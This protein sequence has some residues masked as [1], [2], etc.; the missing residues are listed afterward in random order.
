MTTRREFLTTAAATTAV[1]ASPQLLPAADAPVRFGFSIAKTGRFASAATSQIA[2]YDFWKD[3]VNA[4][5]GLDV[6]GKRR[7]IEFV[8]YDDQGNPAQSAKI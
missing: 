1:L 4:A 5:G 2:T 6:A 7:P 3:Q 8:S